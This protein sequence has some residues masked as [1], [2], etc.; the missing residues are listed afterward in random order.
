MENKEKKGE[1]VAGILFNSKRTQVLLIERRDLPV[2]VLPGGGIEAGESP[3]EAAVR[4]V[5]EETGLR[6]KIARKVA[7]YS[8][9]CR[10]AK[11]TYFFECEILSGNI[12][13]GFETKGVEFFPLN[14]LPRR[15]PPPYRDWIND[16]LV[17]SHSVLKKKITSVTYKAFVRYLLTHPILVIRFLLTKIGVRFQ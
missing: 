11:Y 14:E 4:E 16:A 8:P 13:T 1:S 10:L 7:E 3:E 15:L 2:W 6:V 9:L 12:K 17:P 5:E